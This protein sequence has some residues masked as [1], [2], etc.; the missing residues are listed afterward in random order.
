MSQGTATVIS[1]PWR[2]IKDQGMT[3]PNGVTSTASAIGP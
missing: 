1:G 2:S 3:S